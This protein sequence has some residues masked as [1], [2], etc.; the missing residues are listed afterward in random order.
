MSYRSKY[1][2]YSYRIHRVARAA[3]GNNIQKHLTKGVQ[4]MGIDVSAYEMPMI[5][6]SVKENKKKKLGGCAQKKNRAVECAR[7]TYMHM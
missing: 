3:K 6:K 1:T 4:E 2:I 5:L 7:Y